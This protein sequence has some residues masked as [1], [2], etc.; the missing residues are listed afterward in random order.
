MAAQADKY[1]VKLIGF[2]YSQ[3]IKKDQ[4]GYS[5]MKL[6]VLPKYVLP[7]LFRKQEGGIQMGCIT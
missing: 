6:F 3:S 7:T 1:T 2:F 5:I 4:F